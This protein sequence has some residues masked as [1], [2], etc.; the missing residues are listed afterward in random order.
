MVFIQ[1]YTWAESKQVLPNSEIEVIFVVEENMF[2]ASW[3]EGKVKAYA[4]SLDKDQWKRSLKIVQKAVN[5][6]PTEFIKRHLKKI[7]VLHTLKFFG[8]KFGGTNA[9]TKDAIYLS[10]KGTQL[11]YSNHYIEQVFHAELSSILFNTYPHYFQKDE[12]IKFS[13][14]KHGTSGVTALENKQTSEKFEHRYHNTG[15]LNQYAI[16]SIENDFNSFAKNLF[17]AKRN[18]W[19]SIKSYKL[20]E[21]KKMLTIQFYQKLDKQF[22]EHFFKNISN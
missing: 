3:Y 1:L 18:F 8:Q 5:K 7:Y 12:W 17:V 15:F 4:T 21:Q 20:L 9:P 13:K 11:G 22:N 10:N 19:T 16:S 6:Y 2:P 14:I